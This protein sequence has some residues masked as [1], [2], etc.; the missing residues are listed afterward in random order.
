MANL[1]SLMVGIYRLS[2]IIKCVLHGQSKK[3]DGRYI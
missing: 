3:L 2:T 1:R